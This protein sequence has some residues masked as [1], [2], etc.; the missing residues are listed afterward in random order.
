[1]ADDR[2]VDSA[3]AESIGDYSESTSVASSVFDHQ[4]ENGRR[5]HSYKAGQYFAP[6]DE[7]EQERLD[8]LHHV[9]SMVLGGELYRAPIEEPQR[10][11]DVGT[12]TGIW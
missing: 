1:M 2:D 11:L 6:N 12:G 4:Y 5:Y 7:Q 3:Y 10:V 8:L 9:Q